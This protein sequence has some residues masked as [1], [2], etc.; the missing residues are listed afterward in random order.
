MSQSSH[1]TPSACAW[2][3]SSDRVSGLVG[4]SSQTGYDTPL[5]EVNGCVTLNGSHQA[6]GMLKRRG[7]E[8]A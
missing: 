7:R 3:A 5:N 6:I 2:F 8:V 1:Y 4:I